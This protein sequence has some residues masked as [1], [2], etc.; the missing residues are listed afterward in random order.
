[1]LSFSDDKLGLPELLTSTFIPP[2]PG[3]LVSNKGV[4][5]ALVDVNV[6]GPRCQ[7]PHQG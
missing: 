2:S 6:C 4:Q 3:R 1:M 5:I 7:V